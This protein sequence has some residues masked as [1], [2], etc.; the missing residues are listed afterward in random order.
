M[1]SS[2]KEKGERQ[3]ASP[4]SSAS[5]KTSAEKAGAQPRF[6][7]HRRVI[8]LITGLVA[9]VLVFFLVPNQLPPPL[10]FVVDDMGV[11]QYTPFALK[12]SAATAV[13]MIIWWVSEAIPLAATALVPLVVFPLTHLQ[14]FQAT[15]APYASGTIFLFMGGFFLAFTVQKWGLHKRVALHTVKAVG[16]SPR[17]LVLGMMAATGFLSIWVSNTATAVMMLP[18]GLSILTLVNGGEVK[19]SEL[20]KSNFGKAMM[21]GIAYSASVASLASLIS[22]PPNTMLRAYVQENYGI[23]IGFGQWMLF[24]GPTAVLFLILGWVFLTRVLFPPEIKD[25]PGG[26]ETIQR[27]LNELGPM[28]RGEKLAGIVFVAAALSWLLVPT[29]FP[30]SGISDELIAMIVSLA[31]FAIPVYPRRGIMLL[32]WNTAKGIP[33]NILLLFGGGL[34]LSAAFTKNGLSA[35][36]GYLSRGIGALPVVLIVLAVV[37]VTMAM[38]EMASNTA[39]AAA[40]LPVMGGVATG[41]SHDALLFVV[42]VAMAATCCFMMPMAT[43]PNA[44]AYGTGYLKMGEMIKSGALMA[45]TAVILITATVLIMGPLVLGINY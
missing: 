24:A 12:V 1:T 33:W 30:R 10:R 18:I 22:T 40:M 25:L 23:T 37:V 29:L 41:T 36:I 15:A 3:K 13:L 32:D 26:K 17:M 19:A 42:P 16:T 5:V 11:P 31:V 27:E 34:A 21:L 44:I 35:W 4:H 39:T 14:D 28:S 6:K 7:L 8:G 2:A 38:T 20:V 9:A 45:A 43:P